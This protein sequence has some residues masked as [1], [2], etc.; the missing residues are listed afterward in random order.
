MNELGQA[1]RRLL[2]DGTRSD[3]SIN[4]ALAK[5][6]GDWFEWLLCIVGRTVESSR[7]TKYVAVRLPN[8]T[9]FDAAK[10]YNENLAQMIEGLR[11]EVQ[12]S[13]VELITSNP[14]FVL[15][16][17]DVSD[18]NASPPEFGQNLLD[19]HDARHMRYVGKCGFED[20]KGYLAAKYTLRP[21]RRLQMSHEG[22][23]MK[24]L[25]VHLQTRLW[26]TRPRGLQFYAVSTH[27]GAA[28]KRGLKTVATHS[29]TTVASLPQP[30]VD[31]VFQTTMVSEAHDMF[32]EILG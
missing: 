11:G 31:K 29:I 17:R 27:V 8:V 26:I 19:W 30:A 25:Y 15:I 18:T 20:I 2:G 9:R 10:L 5:L 22:S 3:R 32:S 21:D 14:D 1:A 28:D 13:D 24:A 6:S 23:L 12:K 16:A 4:Q 7:P